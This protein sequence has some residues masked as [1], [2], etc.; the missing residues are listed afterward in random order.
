MCDGLGN[1][2]LCRGPVRSLGEFQQSEHLDRAFIVEHSAHCAQQC[3][4]AEGAPFSLL[5]EAVVAVG[6]QRIGGETLEEVHPL[7]LM[8]RLEVE[9]RSDALSVRC[10]E[11]L[12]SVNHEL[13]DVGGQHRPGIHLQRGRGEQTKGRATR[14]VSTTKQQIAAAYSK[15][16][17]VQK[18]KHKPP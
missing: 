3:L 16:Y 10:L 15:Q 8:R 13:L 2:L 11:L 1:L 9:I 18:N 17:V 4:A 5:H 7:L 6:S 12:G 14:K